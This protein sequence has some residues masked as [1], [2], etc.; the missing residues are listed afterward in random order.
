MPEGRRQRRANPHLLRAQPP[1][2]RAS[3]PRAAQWGQEPCAPAGEGGWGRSLGLSHRAPCSITR[4]L[5]RAVPS[6]EVSLP[7]RPRGRGRRQSPSDGLGDTRGPG[8]WGGRAD[9][10]LPPHFYKSEWPNPESR[11]PGASATLP[12]LRNTRVPCRGL[13]GPGHR[14]RGGWG[15]LSGHVLPP[16][17][18]GPAASVQSPTPGRLQ[19]GPLPL[20]HSDSGQQKWGWGGSQEAWL[21][22]SGL[23]SSQQG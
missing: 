21:G 18:C 17:C 2:A 9:L 22:A 11:A 7:G 14:C 5:R 6:S 8:V 15:E 19:G 1:P 20:A 4:G 13:F 10:H 12:T 3:G 23:H 16:A